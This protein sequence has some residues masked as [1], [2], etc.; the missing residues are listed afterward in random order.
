ML[1][2]V[3]KEM[4]LTS[5]MNTVQSVSPQMIASI[6]VLQ[7]GAQELNEY[8]ENLSYENPMM[9][10]TEPEQKDTSPVAVSLAEKF[11]W[12]RDSDRQNRSYYADADRD[13][14]D[15]YLHREQTESLPD[16]VKEQILTTDASEGLRRAMET[17][18]DLLDG[19]G[20]F[21]G[22]IREIA[23]LANCSEETARHALDLVRELEPAGVA[24]E[25]IQAALLKQIGLVEKPVVR[26][27]LSEYYER[28][29]TWSDQRLAHALG[30]SE[31]SV[32]AA[33]T[34]IASLNPYPSGGFA[35]SETPQYVIPDMS[36][37]E[38]DGALTAVTEDE[39]LPTVHI[40]GDYLRMLET[41]K[42]P[43]V[44]SY[45]REKLRQL[46]Q[47]MGSLDRRK[48]TLLRCGEI[49]AR[50]QEQ[51]FRGGSLRKLTLRDVAEELELHESTISR[52]VK[53]KYIQCD[54]GVF[55]MSA[56]FSRDV[57]Q[58]V[59]LSRS[60]IQEIIVRIID[61]ED[62]KRPLSDEKITDQLAKQHITLSRRAVAK[63][64]ME[65][66]IPAA[67]GRKHAGTNNLPALK[68]EN[69]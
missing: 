2:S 15:Q 26:R 68:Q 55:P 35:N 37:I 20:L 13:S 3:V 57:G 12:L 25:S 18:A 39:Y 7:C 60:G 38:K 66:G 43:A 41:E 48:S 40:N 8:L 33:K 16:F 22:T 30:V 51:F 56:M 32:V 42:D 46:E 9:D 52:A 50:Q 19:R 67:S 65:L 24:A 21:T 11:R 54:R 10:L 4:R 23:G 44:Q 64:R 62:P 63:Y 28:L 59:G 5:S 61:R 69:H 6:G 29:G 31:Q 58:N 1:K 27:I 36:I 14:L 49:I 53:N 34:F 17:V 45:L 47:V